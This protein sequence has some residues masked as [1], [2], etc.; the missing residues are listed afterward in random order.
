MDKQSVFI[1]TSGFYALLTSD[2][3]NHKKSTQWLSAFIDSNKIAF[4]SDYII[5]ETLK[6]T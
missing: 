1:D 2:D 6:I 3:V 4:T 5:D